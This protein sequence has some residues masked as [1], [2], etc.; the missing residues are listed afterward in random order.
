LFRP[1]RIEMWTFQRFQLCTRMHM[2]V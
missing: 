2:N 1:L